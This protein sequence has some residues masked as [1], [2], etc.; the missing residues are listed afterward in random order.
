MRNGDA[1]PRGW[2]GLLEP[3]D[4]LRYPY[5]SDVEARNAVDGDQQ[6]LVLARSGLRPL[7]H[8][9]TVLWGFVDSSLRLR[10]WHRSLDRWGQPV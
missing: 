1:L 8:R 4:R 7:H 3:P 5:D 9:V 6:Q 10:K 2:V